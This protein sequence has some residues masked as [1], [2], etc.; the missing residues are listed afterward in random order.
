MQMNADIQ[1]SIKPKWFLA[2]VCA[3]LRP[4]LQKDFY[5]FSL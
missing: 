5:Q 2:F 1:D 4:F 3:N